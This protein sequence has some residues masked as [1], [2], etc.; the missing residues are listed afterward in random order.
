MFI[1]ICPSNCFAIL[2]KDDVTEEHGSDTALTGALVV[3]SFNIYQ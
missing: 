1:S 3:K 2:L